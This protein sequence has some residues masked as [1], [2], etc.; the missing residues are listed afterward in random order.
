MVDARASLDLSVASK[1]LVVKIKF[2]L[3]IHANAKMAISLLMQYVNS[4]SLAQRIQIGILRLLHVIHVDL[5][6]LAQHLSA[7]Q[8]LYGTVRPVS[9]LMVNTFLVQIV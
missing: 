8:Q 4:Q 3:G 2:L 5:D 7:P 9:A 6:L 1:K